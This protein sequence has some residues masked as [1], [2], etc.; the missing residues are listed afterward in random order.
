[1]LQCT[2][3]MNARIAYSV[4]L[5]LGKKRKKHYWIKSRSRARRPGSWSRKQ[6]SRQTSKQK[7]GAKPHA[8]L[9]MTGREGKFKIKQFR[10]DWGLM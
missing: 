8:Q 4:K 1:M 10:H 9:P 5:R 2:Y 6:T 7:K 3:V